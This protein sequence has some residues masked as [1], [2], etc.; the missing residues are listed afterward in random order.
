MYLCISYAH[1]QYIAHMV[2]TGR[3]SM[4]QYMPMKPVKRGFKVW[5][6]AD[7]VNG[8]FCTFEVYVGRPSDGTTTEVG[9]GERVVLQLSERLRGG[10]YQIYSDNYFTTCHLLDTLRTHHLYGCGT[11]RTARRDFPETLKTVS[12]ERGEHAFCQRGDLVA[13]VWQDKK[14]VHLLSTLAQAD[15][16]HTAQ[17][18]QKDGSRISVQC[19]DAVVLY[20]QHMAGVDRGD[21]LRQYY[22]VR[23]KCRKN[24]KYIFWFLFDVSITNSYILSLFAPTTMPI[25]HQRLK[26]FRLRLANQ[27]VGD[28]NSRKRLGRP[29]SRPAHPPPAIP[30]PQHLG[31]LPPQATRTALHLPSRH[32]K[33]R[34][35]VYCSQYRDPPRR[36][37]VLWQCNVCPGQPSLCF[38]GNEDGSDCFRLWHA[39]LL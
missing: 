19:P 3:S 33:K 5:V 17:R 35:C 11:T 34:R 24:Y 22:R 29:C 9:L 10:N 30:S 15:V 1:V 12:L 16:T 32:D 13:S 26:A 2:P 4:K 37:D 36:R 8:Y 31:P 39:H 23:T 28:Y 25:S 6:R 18:K 27:L 7:S 38:T 21:Q 14:P 20:N